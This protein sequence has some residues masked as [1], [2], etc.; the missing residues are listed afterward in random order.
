MTLGIVDVGTNSIHLL[1]GILGLNGKFHVMLKERDLTRLG[2][3]GLAKGRLTRR[4]MHRALEVLRRYAATIT[5]CHVDRVEAVATSAVREAAN[6]RSF[7]RRVRAKA[8]LPLRVIS[9]REEARLIYLG[10]ISAHRVRRPAAIVTIGGGSAQIIHGNGARLG[11]VSSVPLGGARLAQQFIRHDP[12][13]PGE[14]AALT[15]HVRRVW[16]PVV[17]AMRRHRWEHALG[18]SAT[19][20]QLMTAA[21]LLTHRRHAPPTPRLSISRRSVAQ[22]V[23]W[24]ATSTAQERMQLPGLDPRREDLA[25]PTGVALLAWMEGCGV[26]RLF[27]APGSLREGLVIDYLIRHHQRRRAI[28]HPLAELFSVDGEDMAVLRRPR[29]PTRRRGKRRATVGSR[30]SPQGTDSRT[31]IRAGSSSWKGSMGRGR[32]PSCS[33]CSAGSCRKARPCS[34]PSGTPPSSSRRRRSSGRGPGPSP[35][36]PSA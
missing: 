8:K 24:L 22:L 33:C 34:L 12:P 2:E 25:L 13:R 23:R 16:A 9:G 21:Y 20:Q 11:Y 31:P 15:K 3:G 4:A 17:R 27:Y 14:V 30:A 32:A 28:E 19:I 6:G 36:S 5:R 26:S 7:L 10:V 18:S 35:R 1:I 29:A